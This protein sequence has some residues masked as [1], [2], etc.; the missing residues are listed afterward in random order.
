M[1]SSEASVLII[2][3][4]GARGAVPAELSGSRAMVEADAVGAPSRVGPGAVLCQAL[5]AG[6]KVPS[7]GV[8]R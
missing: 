3:I 4:V 7:R 8:S 5:L 1:A 6:C 2:C